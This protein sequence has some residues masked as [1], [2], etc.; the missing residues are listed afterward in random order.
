MQQYLPHQY[1]LTNLIYDISE[2]TDNNKI[3]RIYDGKKDK[4]LY[5]QT[6]EIVNIFGVIKKKKYLP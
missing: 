2:S 4:P 5:I 6:P 3:I 1:D